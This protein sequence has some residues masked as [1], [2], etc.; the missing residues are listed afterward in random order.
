MNFVNGIVKK[1]SEKAWYRLGF[2][3]RESTGYRSIYFSTGT[4]FKKPG[5]AQHYTDRMAVQFNLP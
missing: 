4:G 2:Q 3:H 5:T 1:Y